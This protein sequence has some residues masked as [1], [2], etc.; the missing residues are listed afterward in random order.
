MS[1]TVQ[2]LWV[3]NRLSRMEYYSIKS[4]LKLGYTFILY[5]YEPV[6]NIIGN[7]I[8]KIALPSCVIQA[9]LF[10]ITFLL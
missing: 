5:T 8:S 4:F 6:A 10:T 7:P 9:V 2:S 3:G 1:L